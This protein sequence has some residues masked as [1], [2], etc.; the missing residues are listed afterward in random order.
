MLGEK[1]IRSLECRVMKDIGITLEHVT[2]SGSKFPQSCLS[3]LLFLCFQAC[4]ELKKIGDM[5]FN[6]ACNV[7]SI[8]APFPNKL[9]SQREYSMLCIVGQ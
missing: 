5:M 1:F 6:K 9:S 2:E 7:N 3:L 8:D 4:G